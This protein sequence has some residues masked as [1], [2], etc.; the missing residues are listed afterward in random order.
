MTQWEHLPRAPIVEALLDIRVKFSSPPSHE[1]LAALHGTVAHDYPISEKL[2]RWE[3]EIQFRADPPPEFAV[4]SGPLGFIFRSA[5]R[6][7]AVQMREDGFTINWLRPY[8]TWGDLRAAAEATWE[9]YRGR[10][11]PTTI[12]RLAVRYINRIELPL[13]FADFREFVRTAPDVAPE[14]PQGLSA[15]F[16]RVEIPEPAKRFSAIITEAMEPLTE[17]STQ[18]PLI[19]DI[20]VVDQRS[21]EASSPL[22]WDSFEL[23]REYKN[24]IFFRSMTDRALGLFR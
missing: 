23:M 18:L 24:E 17:T 15:L 2:V 10:L 9:L 12:V 11:N 8:R 21:I 19:F 3:S 5:D 4:R 1:Q 22:I 13:P 20:D 7:R 16:F 14:L 6:K